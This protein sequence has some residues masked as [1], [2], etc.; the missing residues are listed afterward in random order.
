MFFHLQTHLYSTI[1]GQ[2]DRMSV[3]ELHTVE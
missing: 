2:N 1:I 3:A